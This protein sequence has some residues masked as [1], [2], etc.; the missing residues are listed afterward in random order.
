[1]YTFHALT[2]THAPPKRLTDA[3][4]EEHPSTEQLFRRCFTVGDSNS[5]LSLKRIFAIMQSD[6][7]D[8]TQKK[9]RLFMEEKAEREA[10]VKM[11][12]PKNVLTFSGLTAVSTDQFY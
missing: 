5:A 7:Y 12:R 1:M 11:T 2:R 6:G 4:H 8:G 10:S 3:Y 9:L